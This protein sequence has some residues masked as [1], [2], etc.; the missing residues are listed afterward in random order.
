[1]N[2]IELFPSASNLGSREVIRANSKR[3]GEIIKI[4]LDKIVILKEFNKRLPE[5]Y[6][7]IEGLAKSIIANKQILPGL[8]NVT[9]DG[10]FIL[11]DGHRRYQAHLLAREWGHQ[12]EFE[13][14]VNNNKVSEKDRI[15]MMFLTQD[16]QQLS[17][18]EQAALIADLI[19]KHGMK[20][21][22]VKDQLGKTKQW[23]YD[24]LK[25]DN[26]EEDMKDAVRSGV[27]AATSALEIQKQIPDKQKRRDAMEK[28][29]K[30]ASDKGRSKILPKDV[31]P[32]SD[33]S[34]DSPKMGVTEKCQKIIKTL[35]DVLVVHADPALIEEL[36]SDKNVISKLEHE[37]IK[38]V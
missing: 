24:L 20:V 30:T 8:V 38:I 15:L 10:M 11:T 2:Q 14:I 25:I 31:L 28:A 19:G 23:I 6:G 27:L 21:E 12:T 7:D 32:A 22:E 18:I 3:G 5:N 13:A 37:I 9:K 29:T 34:S 4:P 1:M 36:R 26:V 33:T 17:L 35:F 16:N